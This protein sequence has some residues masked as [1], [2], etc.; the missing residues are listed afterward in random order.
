MKMIAIAAS[1]AAAATGAAAQAPSARLT[2][3]SAEKIIKGC[4]AYSQAKGQSH[5]IAVLD[6]SGN[7]TAFLRME[8]NSGGVAQFALEKAR[9]V[10]LWG[11]PTSSMEEAIKETP[12]FKDAP[13]VVTVAGGVPIFSADGKIFLG[14]VGVSGEAPADDEACAKAGIEKA[15]L[16]HA[17]NR[18]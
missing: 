6:S 9:A 4:S 17:R 11:F 1:L 18:S 3:D 15:G 10:A 8:G 7:L 16:A 2:T 13:H 14:A 12:G 5:A